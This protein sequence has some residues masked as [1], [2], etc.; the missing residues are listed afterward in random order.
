MRYLA[1]FIVMGLSISGVRGLDWPTWLQVVAVVLVNLIAGA[2]I[3]GSQEV[4]E[5]KGEPEKQ[6]GGPGSSENSER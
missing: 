2:L 5:R 6:E 1:F 4:A 3:W